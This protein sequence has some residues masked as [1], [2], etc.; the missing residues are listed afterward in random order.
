MF[1]FFKQLSCGLFLR[2]K[3]YACSRP[4]YLSVSTQFSIK[5][6]GYLMRMLTTG[7]VLRILQIST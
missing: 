6:T 1:Y 7:Q 4:V 5:S 3:S 2:M